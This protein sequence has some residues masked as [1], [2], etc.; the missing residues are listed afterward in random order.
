MQKEYGNIV[1]NDKQAGEGG[2]GAPLS[3]SRQENKETANKEAANSK[4]IKGNISSHFV[5]LPEE[6]LTIRI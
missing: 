6:T 3:V 4:L 5:S 1:W 2:L